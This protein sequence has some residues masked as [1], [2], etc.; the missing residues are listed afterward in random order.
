M[1]RCRR[2]KRGMMENR[3]KRGAA[4]ATREEKMGS[5]HDVEKSVCAESLHTHFSPQHGYYYWGARSAP[6]SVKCPDP[7]LR[8]PDHP[9]RCPD[10]RTL[11]RPPGG[12][13]LDVVAPRALA[14]LP[15]GGTHTAMHSAPIPVGQMAKRHAHAHI[16][17]GARHPFRGVRHPFRG[18]RH[19]NSSEPRLNS[20]EPHLSSEPSLNSSEPH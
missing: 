4:G 11:R 16:R 7:P 6:Q 15:V 19:P 18:A 13:A 20:S 1:R 8:C 17:A 9:L 14:S 10:S 5:N 12:G 2:R 3:G